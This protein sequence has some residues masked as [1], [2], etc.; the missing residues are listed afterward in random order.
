[1]F[2]FAAAAM[3]S[4]SSCVQTEEVYTGQAQEMGFKSAVT[5]AGIIDNSDDMTD[6]IAVAMVLDKEK[7]GAFVPYQVDAASGTAE[8]VYGSTGVWRGNPARY[9]PNTGK[10]NFL[11][12][13]PYPRTATIAT[14]YATDGQVES[15]LFSGI[16]NNK[17]VQNDI[18]YSDLLS[19]DCPQ[20]E[21][22]LL[23]FHHSL[24]QLVVTFQKL[25]A[26]ADVV[27]QSVKLIDVHLGNK[28][29][30][31]A[32]TPNSSAEWL[33]LGSSIN[34]YFLKNTEVSS[35][36]NGTLAE[37]L[38][39]KDA[40]ITADEEPY[41]PLPVLVAPSNQTSVE[42]VYSVDGH[43]YTHIH[44]FQI[45][46]LTDLPYDE[47]K[48]WEMGHKYIYNFTINV[49]EILFDCTVEEWTPG[50]YGPGFP[51]ENESGENITI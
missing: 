45:D 18:L 3:V 15:M 39:G 42:I 5:R 37:P 44:D 20:E 9:W 6:P 2:L 48:T 41:S 47:T 33:D 10:M 19:V 25:N 31:T 1:M 11:A 21:T 24:A 7:N 35:Y 27:L 36:E 8:F 29:K 14:T 32:G 38:K 28:L 46:P 16:D 51:T 50:N 17:V 12:L 49:N 22:Q 30:V 26:S 23:S 43:Q 40:L 34:R 13:S 4:L